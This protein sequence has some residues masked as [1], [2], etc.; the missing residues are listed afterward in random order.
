M[1]SLATT[2]ALAAATLLLTACGA[3]TSASDVGAARAT[4]ATSPGA[5]SPV[6]SSRKAGAESRPTRSQALSFARAVNLIAADI[7][8][9]KPSR[10]KKRRPDP[11]EHP[12]CEGSVGRGP[13]VAEVES[14]R[15][16]RGSELETEEITSS[17]TVRP[18]AA[19][20]AKDL[21]WL[22]SR[23]AR[24]CIAHVLSRRFGGKTIKEAHWG[25]FTVSSL[26]ARAPGA[27]GTVGF[28]IA[29]T[30]SFPVS[31]VSVP[32]YVDVLGFIIGPAEVSLSALS[33]TQPVPPE[34]EQRLLTLLLTR[35]QAHPL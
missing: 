2:C 26:P 8:E 7:P 18:D 4:A 24:E 20:A 28:R 15:L 13:K 27:T 32:L 25:R 17:V 5:A 11:V 21:L 31:E 10:Q 34:T 16:I 35:A 9:A 1:K 23:G 29:T 22:Q 30:L 3:S 19:A 6:S 33:A 14:L 12:R